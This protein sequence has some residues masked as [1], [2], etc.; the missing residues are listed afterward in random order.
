M[1]KKVFIILFIAAA[2]TT[3]AYLFWNNNQDKKTQPTETQTGD[4][5]FFP[6]SQTQDGNQREPGQVRQ[7]RDTE[8][9]AFDFIP[10]TGSSSATTKKMTFVVSA[11]GI[12]VSKAIEGAKDK[13][14][15]VIR[16]IER[17]TGHITDISTKDKI[18][19]VISNT[20]I[21]GIYDIYWSKNGENFLM[22][23]INDKDEVENLY[24]YLEKST[25]PGS[26]S[27]VKTSLLDKNI[28]EVTLSPD[29]T[30]LFYLTLTPSGSVG[31]TATMGKENLTNLKQVFNSPLK[32][33]QISWPISGFIYLNTK[34]SFATEGYLFSFNIKTGTMEKV[35]SGIKGLTSLVSGDGKK[36]VYN[37]SFNEGLATYIFDVAKKESSIFQVQ[38]LP[39]KCIWSKLDT[40][41]IFCS[42]PSTIGSEQYP[43]SWYKGLTSFSDQIW[44]IDT[45]TGQTTLLS[46]TN[47]L[48]PAGF[49]GTNPILSESEDKLLL[50]NKKDSTL[51]MIE[52]Q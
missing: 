21:T 9:E 39:E 44:K 5:V 51:W 19:S 33:W 20:T 47:S 14:E 46:G 13:F 10:T 11:G 17:G 43:D 29:K 32:E 52:L 18:P 41:I 7:T 2:V 3:L 31:T 12:F 4:S 49:D 48:D 25:D 15:T 24:G 34:P 28:K 22:R 27:S 35:L 23:R 8:G 6:I 1:S 36:I 38:T 42:V 37:R 45:Q 40:N 50:T 30:S 16:Q 26:A